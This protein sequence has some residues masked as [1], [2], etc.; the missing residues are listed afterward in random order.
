[1]F[2]SRKYKELG[3]V[4][5]FGNK[6]G[7]AS[8]NWGGIYEK[9][10]W[11][12]EVLLAG[13]EINKD[14][15]VMASSSAL[16][17]NSFSSSCS[18]FLITPPGCQRISDQTSSW[19]ESKS[20]KCQKKGLCWSQSNDFYLLSE[21]VDAPTLDPLPA[22]FKEASLTTLTG[23]TQSHRGHRKLNVSFCWEPWKQSQAQ[24]ISG[25]LLTHGVTSSCHVNFRSIHIEWIQIIKIYIQRPILN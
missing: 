14:R 21:G 4:Y 6:I 1:M 3:R 11:P 19:I 9:R 16:I 15:H 12:L 7:F 8:N 22:L 13:G 5:Y 23:R 20:A 25:R 10:D 2:P 17:C 18:F 24:L